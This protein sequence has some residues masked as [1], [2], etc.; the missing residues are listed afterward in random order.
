MRQFSDCSNR[1]T[2]K[3]MCFRCKALKVVIPNETCNSRALTN[4][5]KKN[6]KRI[7]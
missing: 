1:L 6:T 4:R 7:R 3:N 5:R 2:N